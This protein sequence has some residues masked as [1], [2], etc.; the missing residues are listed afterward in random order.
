MAPGDIVLQLGSSQFSKTIA[1]A[2]RSRFS[3][4][5]LAING[6]VVYEALA[7][8]VFPTTL[9]FG[10]VR[11]EGAEKTAV[12]LPGVRRAVV[13]RHVG[14]FDR[15][16]SERFEVGDELLEIAGRFLGRPYADVL[17][18]LG[19]A[20]QPG[21]RPLS[22]WLG[23][24]LRNG[25]LDERDRGI[26]CSE[27]VVRILQAMGLELFDGHRQPGTIS[28]GDLAT[29][30]RLKPVNGAAFEA[31]PVAATESQRRLADSWETAR[32]PREQFVAT[33]R[34][35]KAVRAKAA[36]PSPRARK[37]PRPKPPR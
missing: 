15:V 13:L 12:E 27:L 1:R 20:P 16:E 30:A 7:D 21:I 19:A 4:A 32:P 2:T 31:A 18:L 24:R 37:A 5:Q 33:D 26:F 6:L 29:S 34:A 9:S 36:A 3:H 25:A 35:I 17:Q 14:F 28:P 23:K 11:H 8:G 22:A 10:S